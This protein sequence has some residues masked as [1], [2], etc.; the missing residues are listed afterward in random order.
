[1]K[2]PDGMLTPLG[3]LAFLELGVLDHRA[4]LVHPKPTAAAPDPLL[5]VEHRAARGEL[6]RQAGEDRHGQGEQEQRKRDRDV[7][8]ALEQPRR[9]RQVGRRHAEDRDPLD[10]V[11][12]DRG[13]EYVDD[14]REESY[15]DVSASEAPDEV[16]QLV[17][18]NLGSEDDY[19]L[20]ALLG[21]DVVDLL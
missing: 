1:E 2:K 18:R 3:E 19:S 17:G 9:S 14:V 5:A 21:D 8:G 7:H 6:D 20:D 10:V 12:L 11:D 16:G 4:E 13:S 15:A